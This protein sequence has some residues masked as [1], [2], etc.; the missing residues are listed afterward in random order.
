M[1][2]RAFTLPCGQKLNAQKGAGS[3][4]EKKKNRAQLCTRGTNQIKPVSAC[5]QR[6]SN[7]EQNIKSYSIAANKSST[8]HTLVHALAAARGDSRQ[9]PGGR[10][11]PIGQCNSPHQ[12]NSFIGGPPGEHISLPLSPVA[13]TPRRVLRV[14]WWR[15]GGTL[16]GNGGGRLQL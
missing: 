4:L 1:N 7:I 3:K 11:F 14:C 10:G 5:A 13:G 12:I 15:P 8:K 9:V 6:S 16:A 2:M